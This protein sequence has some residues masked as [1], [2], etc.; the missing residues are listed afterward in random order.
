MSRRLSGI[1]ELRYVADGQAGLVTAAQLSELGIGSRTVSRRVAGGMWTRVLPGVHLV[2]GGHPTRLQR[3]RAALLYAGEGS[4]LT[5][6]TALRRYGVRALGLQETVAD[7][8]ER[9]EPVHVLIPH[10]RR[11][12]AAGFVVTERTH[13][14][15]TAR[16]VQDGLALTD[17]TRAVGDACR[18]MR[19]A[20]DATTIVTEVSQRGLVDL[21]DLE[22]ELRSGQR[23][24]SA[25]LREALRAVRSGARSSSESDVIQ[26]LLDAGYT[27]LLVNPTLVSPHG[28]YIAIPDVWLDDVALAVEVDSVQY[29]AA[30]DGFRR[31]VRRNARYA[32][33]GIL[34]VTVLPTDVRDRP[35]WVL[36]SVGEAYAAAAARARPQ[37]R[38]TGGVTP[39]AGRQAWRWGA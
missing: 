26:M 36:H 29:H 31:T 32:A 5:G 35:A 37:V 15:P 27:S 39:S 13:R 19:T 8:A 10:A 17:V 22:M 23:R 21:D 20:A 28:A 12:I 3:E 16:R 34:V 33:A 14:M 24:G 4:V 7:E 9:P 1:E 25:H 11:R 30:D 2:H 18:R 38:V 6:L